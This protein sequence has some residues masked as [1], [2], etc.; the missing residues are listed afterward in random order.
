MYPDIFIYPTQELAMVHLVE[1]KLT[2]THSRGSHSVMSDSA[3]AWTV[4]CQVPP[5]M[6]FY[7]QEEWSGLPFP[8]PGD[9]PDS[10]I[11]P[12]SPTLQADLHP[13][14]ILNLLETTYEQTTSL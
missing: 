7:R 11:E 1:I 3:T 6:G 12:R 5:S 9:L 13:Q 8:S 4:A 2:F 10:G 14:V